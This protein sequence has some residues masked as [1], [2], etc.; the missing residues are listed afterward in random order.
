[1]NLCICSL[2]DRSWLYDLTKP[3]LEKYCHKWN[4]DFRFCDEILDKQRA[5]S[6][7][8]LLFVK[9]LINEGKYDWVIWIDDDILITDFDKDIRDF[10]FDDENIILQFDSNIMSEGDKLIKD[11]IN[12]GFMF[13]KCNN[14]TI[15]IIEFVYMIGDWSPH[16]TICNWEQEM[17]IH[18]HNMC[19]DAGGSAPYRILPYRT[20]QS[21]NRGDGK[22]YEWRLGDFSSHF[23]G[24]DKDT[25]IKLIQDVNKITNVN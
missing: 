13:F 25:R 24:I 16:R 4:I 17:F 14:K 18:Y 9:K 19:I 11:E 10:I 23:T 2:S 6:W 15:E 12:C 5:Q 7:S 3:N 21:F 8:K 1:M 20:I 22:K